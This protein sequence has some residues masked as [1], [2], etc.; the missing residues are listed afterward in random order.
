MTFIE[1]TTIL[2]SSILVI[3]VRFYVI[4]VTILT[5]DVFSLV[6]YLD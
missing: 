2:I 4:D 5:A 1:Y 6:V 3:I